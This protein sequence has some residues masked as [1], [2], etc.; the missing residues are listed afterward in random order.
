MVDVNKLW[1]VYKVAEGV[2]T[3]LDNRKKLKRALEY[4]QKS[5]DTLLEV[6]DTA[7]RV[8]N[9]DVTGEDVRKVANLAYDNRHIAYRAIFKAIKK[10]K[11][12][13][14]KD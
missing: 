14:S 8:A 10:S 13:E 3:V 11:K 5:T 4:H 9:D 2:G 12:R 7:F 1:R 6:A